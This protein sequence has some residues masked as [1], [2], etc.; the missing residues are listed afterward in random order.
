MT[1]TQPDRC[2]VDIDPVTGVERRFAVEILD[3]GVESSTVLMSMPVFGMTNP[4]TGA[5]TLSPLAILVDAAAGRANHLGRDTDEWSVTSELT[6]ELSLDA[7][8][9]TEHVVA[10]A[11]TLGR[12]GATSVS[13]CTLTQGADTVGYGTVRSYF[14]SADRMV[15]DHPSD[16]PSGT[17]QRTL[18]ELMAVRIQSADAGTPVLMQEP[19]PAIY[20]RIGAIHGGIAAAGLE[21]AASATL[22]TNGRHMTS[23]SLRANFLRP[24]LGSDHSRYVATPLRIGRTSAVADAQAVGEDGKAAVI[25]RITAYQR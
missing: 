2:E 20:N 16:P 23:A 25:A 4:F 11:H 1:A 12:Q 17:S 15:D 13:L 3:L 21:L 6:L 24:F 14:I 5:P 10:A 9:P 8:D 18:A 7:G 19:N 22:N